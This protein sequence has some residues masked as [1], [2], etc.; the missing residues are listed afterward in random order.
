MSYKLIKHFRK[1][2][3]Y[4]TLSSYAADLFMLLLDECNIQ[5]WHNPFAVRTQYILDETGMSRPTFIK[6]WKELAAANLITVETSN[7]PK[8]GCYYTLLLVNDVDN[9]TPQ[10]VKEIDN[11]LVNEIYNFIDLLVNEIYKF[12]LLLVND[13]DNFQ[14][15]IFPHTPLKKK[16]IK[17]QGENVDDAPAPPRTREEEFF[18]S[19]CLDPVFRPSGERACSGVC[20]CYES[21]CREVIADWAAAGAPLDDTK[22]RREHLRNTLRK[23][24]EDVRRRYPSYRQGALDFRISSFLA[25]IREAAAAMSLGLDAERDACNSFYL[26]WAETD[27]AGRL[28]CESEKTWDTSMRLTKWLIK[29]KLI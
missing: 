23:K 24:A 14:K 26:Y 25:E 18:R 9:S 15:E 7:N 5:R 10:L 27:A 16:Y 20:D 19:V 17:Q 29:D 4:R 13:V 8:I 22:D 2:R 1:L 3:R 12:T 11:L 21:L 28:R 6:A